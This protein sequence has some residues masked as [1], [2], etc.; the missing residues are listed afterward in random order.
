M[1]DNKLH[2]NMLILL[3]QWGQGMISLKGASNA[4]NGD[5]FLPAFLGTGMI[6]LVFA[7]LFGIRRGVCGASAL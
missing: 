2:Y 1:F 6:F 3:T 5:A 7:V 4:S